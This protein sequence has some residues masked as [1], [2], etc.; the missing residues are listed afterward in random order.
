VVVEVAPRASVVAVALEPVT[1][2]PTPWR[3]TV[4]VVVVVSPVEAR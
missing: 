1:D 4:P 2:A 3:A